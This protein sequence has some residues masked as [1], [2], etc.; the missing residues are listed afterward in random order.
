MIS[1]LPFGSS[2]MVLGK[3]DTDDFLSITIQLIGYELNCNHFNWLSPAINELSED[4]FFNSASGRGS[5]TVSSV[6]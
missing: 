5:F 6:C 3:V 2:V 4:V 1:L